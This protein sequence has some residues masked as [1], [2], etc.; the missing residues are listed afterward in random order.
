MKRYEPF[1][2]NE[3]NENYL[4]SI[5]NKIPNE[6]YKHMFKFLKK[7]NFLI[8]IQLIFHPKELDIYNAEQWYLIFLNPGNNTSFNSSIS[9]YGLVN[10][11]VSSIKSRGYFSVEITKEG[12]IYTYKFLKEPMFLD[13]IINKKGAK[14]IK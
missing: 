13:D 14:I 8:P 2:F 6:V 9:K 4:N 10:T 7:Y 5:K 11:S 3:E 12:K 1:K